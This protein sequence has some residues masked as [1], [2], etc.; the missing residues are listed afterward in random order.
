M[1]ACSGSSTRT[2]RSGT[3]A[4]QPASRT[5]ASLVE[6]TTGRSCADQRPPLPSG[7]LRAVASSRRSPRTASSTSR[8]HAAATTT[9]KAMLTWSS[10][11]VSRPRNWPMSWLP[12]L[13]SARLAVGTRNSTA[14]SSPT[15]TDT[16]LRRKRIRHLPRAPVGVRDTTRSWIPNYRRSGSSLPAAWRGPRRGPGEPCA[17]PARTSGRA[18]QGRCR[19]ITRLGGAGGGARTLATRNSGS[20][21]P[22]CAEGRIWRLT[23]R[24]HPSHAAYDDSW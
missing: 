16:Q 2:G 3:R 7:R 23:S 4:A 21:V 18:A 14:T 6:L 15:A 24:N 12:S 11:L 22:R 13:T 5:V 1:R 10:R 9:P 17:D 20:T 19:S 8:A